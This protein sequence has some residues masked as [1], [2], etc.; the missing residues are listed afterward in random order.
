MKHKPELQ[1]KG[2]RR[3]PKMTQLQIVLLCFLV[4]GT[5]PAKSQGLQHRFGRFGS[6]SCR[7]VATLSPEMP[8]FE[9]ASSAP[10]IT[11]SFGRSRRGTW[12]GTPW[13]WVVVLFPHR[14]RGGAWDHTKGRW[15]SGRFGGVELFSGAAKGRRHLKVRAPLRP[16]DCVQIHRFS[17]LEWLCH[18]C[19]LGVF[20]EDVKKKKKHGCIE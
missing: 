4:F 18:V 8:W 17:D 12:K 19:P 10:F 7:P 20:L 2:G 9:G 11:K 16:G 6:E 1:E 15:S 14:R 13:R 3:I 5:F